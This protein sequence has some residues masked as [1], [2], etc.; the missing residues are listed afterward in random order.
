MPLDPPIPF[1]EIRSGEALTVSGTLFQTFEKCPEQAAGRLRGVYGPESRASFV[2][3]LAHRVFARHLSA[4]PIGAEEFTAVCREEIGSSMNPKLGALGLKPSQLQAIVD[5]V[6]S[7]YERFRTLGAEGFEGAEVPLESEPADGVTL[8]GKVDAV[9]GDGGAGT[10]LVDWKTGA[11]GEPAA[12]LGFYALLWA[13]ER[14]EIPGKVEAVSVSSGERFEEVPSRAGITAIAS[15]VAEMV[16]D[17]RSAWDEGT[18]LPRV[19][20]PWCRWC[21]LLDECSEGQAAKALLDG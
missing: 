3:G 12:Q 18:D 4:G 10:R 14:G 17:L 7:L 8:R 11:L 15:R 1:P 5:E 16:N 6:G 19:A 9:F 2:G 13:L 21:P 20:G